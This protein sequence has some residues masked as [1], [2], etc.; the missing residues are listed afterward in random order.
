MTKLF[1]KRPGNL[2]SM[3]VDVKNNT[4]NEAA[5]YTYLNDLIY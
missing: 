4:L 5:I 3:E 1:S 2:V